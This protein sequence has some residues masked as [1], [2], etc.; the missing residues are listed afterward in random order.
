MLNREPTDEEMRA[1]FV[2]GRDVCQTVAH[3]DPS[4]RLIVAQVVILQVLVDV[5]PAS[6]AVLDVLIE[7]LTQNRAQIGVG[8]LRGETLQ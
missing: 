8:G 7:T 6:G 4:L 3:L 1:A 5:G 2:M